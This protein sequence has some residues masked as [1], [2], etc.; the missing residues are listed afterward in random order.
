MTSKQSLF[1]VSL[2][3]FVLASGVAVAGVASGTTNTVG[4]DLGV[5][6]ENVGNDGATVTVTRN[7][8]AVANASVTVEAAVDGSYAGTGEYETGANGTVSLPD[9]DEDVTVEVIAATGNA[10]GSTTTT[11]TAGDSDDAAGAFGQRVS[12]FVHEILGAGDDG[13]PLGHLVSEFATENNPGNASEKKPDHAGGPGAA[14][15]TGDGNETGADDERGPPD[16]AGPDG[17][18]A[19]ESGDSDDADDGEESD[20]DDDGEASDDEDGGSRGPPDH[21]GNGQGN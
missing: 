13:G 3:G 6:V 20:E 17:D 1:A 10:T 8:S 7:G 11:L 9:P 12:S 14:N 21:A 2:V 5:A 15:E 18:D 4:N 19:G 16:H